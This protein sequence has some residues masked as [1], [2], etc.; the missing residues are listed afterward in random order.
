MDIYQSV[1]APENKPIFSAQNFVEDI[2]SNEKARSDQKIQTIIKNKIKDKPLPL[3][4]PERSNT[5]FF[6]MN[7]KNRK[8]KSLTLTNRQKKKMHLY[9]ISC[10]PTESAL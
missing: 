2:V 10:S 9:E 5:S 1:V 8:R 4:N 7:K 3:D 6:C